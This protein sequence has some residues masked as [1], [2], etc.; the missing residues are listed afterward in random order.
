MD[1]VLTQ[2]AQ[3]L[4]LRRNIPIRWIERTLEAPS[5]VEP[6]SMDSTLEHRLAAIPE[7]GNRGLRV[8]VNKTTN[9]IRVVTFYFDR[10][11]RDKL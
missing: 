2:H 11:L 6:D 8:I 3:D 10:N 1:Y 7:Y 5:K 4:L 9:P